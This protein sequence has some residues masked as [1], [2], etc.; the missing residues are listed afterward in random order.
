MQ[1]SVN[2]RQANLTIKL[3]KCK[4]TKTV[5]ALGGYGATGV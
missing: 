2:F 5:Q 1:Q 4:V 3:I